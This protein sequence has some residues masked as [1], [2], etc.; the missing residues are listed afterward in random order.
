[1]Y[2]LLG[3]EA[4][5]LIEPDNS[6]NDTLHLLPLQFSL[7]LSEISPAVLAGGQ[8]RRKDRQNHQ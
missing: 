1:M 8:C 6:I 3:Q 5:H 2:I 7:S 4:H